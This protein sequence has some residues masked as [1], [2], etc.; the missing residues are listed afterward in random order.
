MKKR[1]IVSMISLILILSSLVMLGI[2]YGWLADVIDIGSGTISVGDLRYT[3]NG[4]FV[5]NGTI[6]HPNE[7]LIQT[8]IDLTNSSPITSQLRVKITYTK[9]TN[10]GGV[11]LVIENDYIYTDDPSEHITVVFDSSFTYDTGYWYYNGTS[12]E[13]AANSGLLPSISSILYDGENTNID[14]VGQNFAV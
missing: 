3:E 2:T 7:E 8:N 14:Y 13:L 4:E 9:I 6:I 5:S 1:V 11:G 10:P 12:G